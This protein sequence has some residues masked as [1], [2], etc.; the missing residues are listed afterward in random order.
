M[1]KKGAYVIGMLFLAIIA[2]YTAQAGPCD[3]WPSID[4]FGNVVT[5]G[6][7]TGQG[8]AS[9]SG[10]TAAQDITATRDITAGRNM[11]AL[12]TITGTGITSTQNINAQ[13]DVIATR[14]VTAGRNLAVTGTTTLTGTATI[15][16]ATAINNQLDVAGNVRLGGPT[17]T[18]RITNL[19]APIAADDA[20]T[21]G[22]VDAAGGGGGGS[23]SGSCYTV[24]GGNTCASGFTRTVDGY[25][26][27]YG[28]NVGGTYWPGELV[29]SP[30]TH[31]GG[32]GN[33]QGFILAT[34]EYWKTQILYNE[35]CAICCQTTG[36]GG[37]GSSLKTVITTGC[38]WLASGGNLGAI[39][40]GS[41][42]CT[43]RSC[44][45]GYTDLGVTGCYPSNGY[46]GTGS[47][48]AAGWCTRTCEK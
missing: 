34:S 43:P 11:L 35:Q 21:K 18:Y 2:A 28:W 40:G 20:A 16:G 3:K 10:I 38:T 47:D 33:P 44:P 1:K 26:T 32:P 45:A 30:V 25:S 7:L 37:G 14:D 24:Y 27:G 29:C 41:D 19:A 22:Y 12:G 23:S 17:P 39:L 42:G 5:T 4:D 31:N 13:Q 9:S 15:T 48:Y 8:L 6:S 46:T 36:A